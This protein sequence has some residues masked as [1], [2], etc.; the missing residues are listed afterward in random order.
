MVSKEYKDRAVKVIAIE[1]HPENYRALLRNLRCNKFENIVIPINKVVSNYK[2]L[3]NLYERSHDGARVESYLYSVCN[4][5]CIDRCNILYASGKTLEIECDT[6]D[7]VLADYRAD[8]I[9]MD[10]EG[11]EVL[12][13]KGAAKTAE[14]AEDSSRDRWE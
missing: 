1:A 11:A 7:N 9:K 6:L 13:L 2:G 12:A 3:V 4:D 8:V 5:Q 10:I 14:D